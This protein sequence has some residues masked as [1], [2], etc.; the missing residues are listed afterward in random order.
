MWMVKYLV[1]LFWNEMWEC[2]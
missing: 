1:T 2:S